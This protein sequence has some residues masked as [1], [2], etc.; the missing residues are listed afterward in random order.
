MLIA[1]S[2]LRTDAGRK[3]KNKRL[4]LERKRAQELER[5]RQAQR[6]LWFQQMVAAYPNF[7][8]DLHPPPPDSPHLEAL[9]ESLSMSLKEFDETGTVTMLRADT[10]TYAAMLTPAPDESWLARFW[11]RWFK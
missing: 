2:C 10:S 3:R 11:K 8:F 1:S 5:I 4:A 7:R 6:E 9:V